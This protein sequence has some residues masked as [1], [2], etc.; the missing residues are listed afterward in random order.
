M[1]FTKAQRNKM[2]K[3][4][5]KEEYGDSTITYDELDAGHKAQV[6]KTL[7]KVAMGAE[8]VSA[9]RTRARAT[10][11]IIEAEIGRVSDNGLKKGALVKGA[12][13][14]DLLT[15]QKFNVNSSKEGV[16]EKSTGNIVELD[17]KV[18]NGETYYITTEIESNF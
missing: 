6:T 1:E 10:G 13:I 3:K 16:M 4:L 8:E 11:N 15:Q 12:T 2:A 7:K 18:K 9:P 17:S 14:Q 5:Y